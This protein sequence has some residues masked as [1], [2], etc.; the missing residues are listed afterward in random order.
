MRSPRATINGRAIDVGPNETL[1]QAALRQGVPFPFSCRVGGCGTCRCRLR[2]GRVRELTEAAYLLDESDIRDGAILACQSVPQTDVVVEV[3][4][5]AARPA[6]SVAGRVAA[7]R[8]LTHDI[9]AL[10]VQL[11]QGL[12]YRAG[13]YAEVS[14]ATLPSVVRNYSFAT[15]ARPDS[16]VT[17]FVR[18]MPH[19]SF[20]SHV[21]VKDLVGQPA[22]VDGPHG[23]FWLRPAEA[24]LLLVAGGSGLAPI[25]ALLQDAA[26]AGVARPA[27]LVFGARTQRDLFALEE[28]AAIARRWRGEFRFVPVLSDAGD[29]WQGERGRVTDHL[30]RHVERGVHAYLCG[31]PAMVDDAATQLRSLGVTPDSIHSDRFVT[32]APPVAASAVATGAPAARD[33]AQKPA[34]NSSPVTA[35]INA[36]LFDYLKFFVFYGVGVAVAVAMVL[37]GAAITAALALV[38]AFYVI[39]DGVGGVDLTTPRYGRPRALTTLLWCALPLLAFIVFAAVWGASEGDP[40][41]FGGWVGGWSGYDML[42]AKQTASAGHLFSSVALTGLMIGLIGTITAHELIHRT[43]DRTSVLIGRALLMFSF[44]TVFAIEHVYGHH[45]YVSTEADPATAPRGRNAYAHIVASTIKGNVSAWRIESRRLRT[46][47]HAVL[48]WRNA[49]LRGHTASLALVLAAWSMGGWRAAVFFV[50]CALWGK[51]LLE[52]VNYMEHY[53][54]VRVATSAVQP[55]HSWNSNH[56]VSSWSSFNLT[57]HSHHH[58]Q[59][60]LPYHELRPFPDAPMMLQGYLTTILIALVPPVWHRLMTPKLLEWDRR[61]ANE[62]EQALASAANARSGIR[63]LEAAA[64]APSGAAIAG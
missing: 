31:S 8:R 1:L 57:R 30:A 34:A 24:P 62:A 10:D 25:L 63:R 61:W 13:Q 15:P 35:R 7:Q 36:T 23:D 56:R 46:R 43:W 26:D 32:R 17:F 39:G 42:A 58:A 51:A 45:R 50:A 40:L 49:V 60:E 29:D 12:P 11:D 16:R 18:H 48:S 64:P 54:L 55:H 37:G 41:G 2:Q 22:L 59:G 4:L 3:D 52:I 21:D 14:L 20:S 9:T 6:R 5:T 19:G 53:G 28:I 27:T 33:A 47:G 38:V 44:D